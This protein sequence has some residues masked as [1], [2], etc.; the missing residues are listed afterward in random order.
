MGINSTLNLLEQFVLSLVK[1]LPFFS[2][3][4]LV[5]PKQ[6]YF[7]AE[8]KSYEV[9]IREGEIMFVSTEFGF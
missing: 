7:P 1:I 2:N 6:Q 9:V 4:A 3:G 8:E 5:K